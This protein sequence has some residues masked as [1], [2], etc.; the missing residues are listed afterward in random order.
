MK[1]YVKS[2]ITH[3]KEAVYEKSFETV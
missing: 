1:I 2:I 3:I